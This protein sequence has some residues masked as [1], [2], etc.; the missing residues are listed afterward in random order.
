MKKILTLAIATLL[1]AN[2]NA[3]VEG[4]TLPK[5]PAI[6]VEASLLNTHLSGFRGDIG[7]SIGVKYEKNIPQLIDVFYWNAGLNIS[8]KRFKETQLYEETIGK[9]RVKAIYAEI[10]IHFGYRYA[11]DDTFTLFGEVGP[12]LAF[13]LGGKTSV[14]ETILGY[15]VTG[16]VNTFGSNRLLSRFDAGLGIRIGATIM[17]QWSLSIG[18]DHGLVNCC[19]D[20]DNSLKPFYR[21][22]CYRLTLGYRF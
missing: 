14:P 21:N 20:S 2:V 6:I 17:D 13:G 9:E 8:M 5:D 12:Y 15:D 1:A 7:A 4:P 11:L 10:P 22:R 18:Y 16:K 3:Q 19:G